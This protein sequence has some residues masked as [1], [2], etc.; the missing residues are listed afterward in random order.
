MYLK[1]NVC[2]CVCVCILILFSPSTCVEVIHLFSVIL[3]IALAILI[4]IQ[5]KDKIDSYYWQGSG[6]RERSCVTGW[7]GNWYNHSALSV[8][9]V[10][11][12]LLNVCT[13]N[14]NSSTVAMSQI[15]RTTH[16]FISS[17]MN[18]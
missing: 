8:F 4:C 10:L 6:T 3:I 13:K 5:D 15:F 2:A 18:L 14:V 1:H 17:R 16:I 11:D 9:Y 12:K 7:R